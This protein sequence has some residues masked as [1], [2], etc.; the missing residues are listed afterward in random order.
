MG[1]EEFGASWGILEG[2]EGI[3]GRHSAPCRGIKALSGRYRSIP[4]RSRFRPRSRLNG[5]A[6]SSMAFAT[7]RSR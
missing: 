6:L 2:S 1:R 4:P 5:M 7:V 3:V